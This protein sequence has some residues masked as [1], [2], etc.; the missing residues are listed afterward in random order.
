[1]E[2]LAWP[3]W[4]LSQLTFNDKFIDF[5]FMSFIIIHIVLR[6]Y[7][8]DCFFCFFFNIHIYVLSFFPPLYSRS[9]ILNW[10][11][12]MEQAHRGWNIWTNLHL[13]LMSSTFE[14][15]L[16]LRLRSRHP[17]FSEEERD[18]MW[19]DEKRKKSL[20]SSLSIT[21]E[22]LHESIVCRFVS[23]EKARDFRK[24]YR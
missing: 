17:C 8:I 11:K 6:I 18:L 2:Q 14:H 21:A 12:F 13:S 22:A 23:C 16:V 24:D 4:A 5:F 1:M 7:N 19:R 15:F 3:F 9:F 20:L 10:L